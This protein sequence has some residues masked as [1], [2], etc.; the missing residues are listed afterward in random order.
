M[1]IYLWP[2]GTFYG[3]L[4]YFMTI[5]DILSPFAIFYDH[6]G[7]F[8]TIWYNLCSFGTFFPVLVSCTKK[9]LATLVRLCQLVAS[10]YIL[11]P[12][13]SE[14]FDIFTIS[15][16]RSNCIKHDGTDG[17][18]NQADQM[19]LSNIL[20]TP[21]EVLGKVGDCYILLLG[22]IVHVCTLS[23]YIHYIHTNI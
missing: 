16:S 9:N 6:L 18:Y 11:I 4:G 13:Y 7:Y 12:T 5:W 21:A 14:G 1:L 2:F 15:D 17:R 22:C 19:S 20:F 8:M 10:R 3:H 23:H